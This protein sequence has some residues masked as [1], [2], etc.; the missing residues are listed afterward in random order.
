MRLYDAEIK[1]SLFD[2]GIIESSNTK[3]MLNRIIDAYKEM[4]SSDEMSFNN[5]VFM[6]I[7]SKFV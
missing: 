3:A 5:P 2:C 6:R 1:K 4:S 7:T